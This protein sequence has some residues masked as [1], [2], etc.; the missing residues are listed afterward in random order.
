MKLWIY[1]VCFIFAF[2]FVSAGV[3]ICIDLDMPSSPLSLGVSGDASSRTLVWVAAVDEPDCSGIDEY[4]ISR[5]GFE[6][7]RV[8]G[9]VLSFVDGEDLSAG[10]YIYSVYA[11]DLIGQNGGMAVANKITIGGGSSGGGSSGSSSSSYV[12]VEDWSCGEW[13]E[14]VGNDMRRICDDLNKCGTQLIKPETYQECGVGSDEEDM[15]VLEDGDG[16]EVSG[17]NGFFS[18]ITG[19][20]VGVTSTTGG[21]IV[22]VFIVLAVVGFGAV[23]IRRKL[24]K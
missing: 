1:L 9:D 14:C 6:I 4:V 23:G 3:Q 18:A 19:A 5:E 10:D 20:V 8:D 21:L 2:S 15:V 13:S 7:G 17:I 22:S 16:P 11:I 24:R 12:C